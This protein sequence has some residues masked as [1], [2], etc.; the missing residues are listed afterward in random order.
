MILI[1][2]FAEDEHTLAVRT[3]LEHIG[4]T[5]TLLDLST[6]PM[7]SAVE[8]VWQPDN[9]SVVHLPQGTVDL[10]STR[11]LWWRRLRPYG[12]DPA[13]ADPQ[14]RAFAANETEHAMAG[15]L[16]A[17]SCHWINPRWNDQAA[18]QKPLQWS[19]AQAV[20]LQIPRTLVTSVPQAAYEFIRQLAPDRAVCKAFLALPNAWRETRLVS[21][22]DLSR[23][24]A[25]RL[26]PVI[27]QQYIEGVDLRVTVVGQELFAAEIDARHSSYPVDMRMV[28]GE[29]NVRP[30]ELPP[31]VAES[32]H[33]LMQRLGLVYGALDL[34]RTD[35]GQ[36]YFLEVNPAGQWLFAEQRAGL[37]IT[38]RLA[39]LIGRLSQTPVEEATVVTPSKRMRTLHGR[40][41]IPPDSPLVS[42]PLLRIEVHDTSQSD[43]A[44]TV[45]A[46]RSLQHVAMGGE[47]C[48]PFEFEIPEVDAG[49]ALELQVHASRTGDAKLQSGD[50]FTTEACPVPPVGACAALQVDLAEI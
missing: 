41:R 23:M 35:A 45:I 25:V 42:V 13:I 24:Q 28:I 43:A 38:Q 31:T 22:E 6:I 8:F 47:Q 19:V 37:P 44:S 16:D 1:V 11:V 34:K 17:L 10:R 27:F 15:T 48:V 7:R 39:A 29:A 3:A 49:H 20:G 36:Y 12:I 30:V 26:A 5:S 2:S 50:W 18:H 9:H 32:I 21:E 40:I 46:A 14:M 33:R 4:Y